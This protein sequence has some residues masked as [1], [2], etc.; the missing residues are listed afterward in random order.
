MTAGS[1]SENRGGGVYIYGNSCNESFGEF[2][3]QGGTISGNLNAGIKN[4][5]DDPKPW[6]GVQVIASVVYSCNND[7]KLHHGTGIFKM[8]GGV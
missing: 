7:Y 8:S 3:M 2:D 4:S 1:I 5:T 6:F